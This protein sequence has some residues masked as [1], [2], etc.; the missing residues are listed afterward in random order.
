LIG[1]RDP[2]MIHVRLVFA[3]ILA[4]VSAAIPTSS[5]A[6]TSCS[7]RRADCKLAVRYVFIG[8]NVLEDRT[9]KDWR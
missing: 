8:S 5:S 3:S 1:E 2:S 6:E 9:V 4:I 7:E